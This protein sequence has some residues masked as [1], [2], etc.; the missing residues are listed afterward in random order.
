M[1]RVDSSQVPI[2][3]ATSLQ[4]VIVPGT[5][6]YLLGESLKSPSSASI[7]IHLKLRVVSER[8]GVPVFSS[9]MSLLM[10]ELKNLRF[11]EQDFLLQCT[12][13]EILFK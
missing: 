4:T 9:P 1:D 8:L 12:L 13:S 6:Q 3:Q 5:S 11:V 7:W 2:S 10:M